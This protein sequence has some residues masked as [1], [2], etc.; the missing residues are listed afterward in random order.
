[1]SESGTHAPDTVYVIYIATTPAKLWVALTSPEFTS[2]YFFGRR[3][4]SDW[5]VDSCVAP[6]FSVLNFDV[7]CTSAG[8]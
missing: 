8:V 2:Q 4:E 3:I 1:M 7:Q 6:L 5:K